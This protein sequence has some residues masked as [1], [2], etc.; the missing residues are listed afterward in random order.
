MEV[1]VLVVLDD[2]VL[3]ATPNEIGAHVQLRGVNMS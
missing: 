1:E 2:I 3:A